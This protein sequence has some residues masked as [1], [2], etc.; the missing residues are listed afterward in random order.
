MEHT[1]NNKNNTLPQISEDTIKSIIQHES[2]K[3]SIEAQR[4]GLA[5]QK[6]KS[7]AELSKIA[8]EANKEIQKNKPK[9]TRYNVITY[10]LVTF[11]FLI[12]LMF[13]FKYCLD[14]GHKDFLIDIIKYTGYLVTTLGGYYL[15][16]KSRKEPNLENVE[17]F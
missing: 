15:G 12:I 16:R 2:A 4:I 10:A 13:G 17:Q 14:H 5:Q 8:I 1:G 7:D 3:L 6:Q 9:E 11:A